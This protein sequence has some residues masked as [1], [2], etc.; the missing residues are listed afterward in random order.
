MQ[1]V[2]TRRQL[3]NEN[4]PTQL[5][6]LQVLDRRGSDY[7]S[8]EKKLYK[9]LHAGTEG[10]QKLLQYLIAFGRPHWVGLQNIWFNHFRTFE[11]DM[12]LFTKHC[13]YIFEV[14]N[15]RGTFS[16]KDGKCFFNGKES[17]L[18]PFEQVRANAVSVRNYL[19]RLN[20]DI[21]VKAAVIF[22]GSDNEV[23]LHSEI[24]AIEVVQSNGIRNFILRIIAE[25][26]QNPH[27]SLAPEFIIKKLEQIETANPFM[28]KPLSENSLREI[29]GGMYCANCL[30][31]DTE[32]LKSKI[33][34]ECGLEES[35]EEALIRC[36]CEYSVLNFHNNKIRRKELLQFLDEQVSL[37]F[38]KGIL[39]EH[40]K[41]TK[42]SSHTYYTIKP[43]LYEQIQK[44]FTI[45]APRI[46][47]QNEGEKTIYNNNVHF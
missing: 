34:C 42:K 18:N 8:E 31:F 28:P 44:E 45:K 22:T 14:K 12:V 35:L 7:F 39:S 41:P 9:S 2:Q 36:I 46:F 33:R 27:H 3:N 30:S 26:N 17:P 19:N 10:E 40:F 29:K 5:E 23:H 13:I 37:S 38:L 15:Y 16:Y 43:R 24:E 47:Y 32:R 25:E 4:L 20:I 6:F 11:C 21:P 1:K